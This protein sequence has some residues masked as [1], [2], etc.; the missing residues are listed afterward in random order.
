LQGKEEALRSAFI[1][2]DADGS[3]HLDA[4][5][6]AA[7]LHAT[8]FRITKHQARASAATALPGNQTCLQPTNTR[9]GFFC[10]SQARLW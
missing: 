9:L 6:L 1:E 2:M 5:E 10:W 4:E 3:G 8:G 7:C